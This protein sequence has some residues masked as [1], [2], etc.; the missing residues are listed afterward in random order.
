MQVVGQETCG[1]CGMAWRNAFIPGVIELID[2]MENIP[3]CLDVKTIQTSC[4][5]C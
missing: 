3:K 4:N 1:P 2:Y 5:R